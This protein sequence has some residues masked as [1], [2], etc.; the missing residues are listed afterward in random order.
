MKK[1][2]NLSYHLPKELSLDA[3]LMWLFIFLERNESVHS[4][5]NQFFDT[6]ILKPEDRGKKVSDLEA[7]RKSHIWENSTDIVLE[8][9]LDGEPRTILFEN[10]ISSMTAIKGYESMY[11]ALY[12]IVYIKMGAFE[13]QE[14]LLAQKRG[15]TIKDIPLLLTSL[16]P[17]IPYS[18]IIA[19]YC[20]YLE[21][22]YG[23]TARKAVGDDINSEHLY[24]LRAKYMRFLVR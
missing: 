2:I 17:L 1:Q 8:F 9:K 4:I 21:E 10:R 16:Q 7:R 5:R 11:T 18:S 13:H 14:A 23:V 6:L 12:G 15:Y 3:F 22:N 24:K 20:L 19:H